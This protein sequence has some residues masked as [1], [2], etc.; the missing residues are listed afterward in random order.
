MTRLSVL[1]AQFLVWSPLSMAEVQKVNGLQSGC[2]IHVNS[3][4]Y[5]GIAS[6]TF[7]CSKMEKGNNTMSFKKRKNCTWNAEMTV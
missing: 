4:S 6:G 7:T 1:F 3:Q 2:L 5:E